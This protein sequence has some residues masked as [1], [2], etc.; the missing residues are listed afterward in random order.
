MRARVVTAKVCA[1]QQQWVAITLRAVKVILL[2]AHRGRRCMQRLCALKLPLAWAVLGTATVLVAMSCR[3]E[4]GAV[5]STM[6]R[7]RTQIAC[8]RRRQ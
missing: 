4:E 3:R 8:T 7:V 6:V 2:H 1:R 5:Q